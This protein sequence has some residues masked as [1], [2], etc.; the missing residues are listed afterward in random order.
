MGLGAMFKKSP[1]NGGL[2][3]YAVVSAKSD[4]LALATWYENKG[5]SMIDSYA[6]RSRSLKTHRTPVEMIA[7]AR[8][9]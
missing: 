7:P 8:T 3:V 9:T 2:G 5:S 4:A 1:S 6:L